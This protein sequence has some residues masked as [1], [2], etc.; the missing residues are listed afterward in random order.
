MTDLLFIRHGESTWNAAGRWQGQGDPSLSEAGRHQA[1]AAAAALRGRDLTLLA[2]SDLRRAAETADRIG[3]EL[4]L[5]VRFVP[6]LR[7]LDVGRWSG[8]RHEEIARR[9]PDELA[10]FRSGDPDVRPGG[11]ESRR[12]LTQRVTAELA[13][14]ASEAPGRVAVVSH[15]GVLRALRPGAELE[16]AAWVEISEG[17]LRSGASRYHDGRSS[18]L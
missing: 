4:G 3:A 16:N 12:V 5:R 10:R 6:G 15:L 8:L 11:G 9:F 18:R 1:A 17:E 2:A 14:L 7:E 13:G